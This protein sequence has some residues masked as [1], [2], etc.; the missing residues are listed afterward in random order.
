M[1]TI[2]PFSNQNNQFLDWTTNILACIVSLV[3]SL[4]VAIAA[5]SS[6]IEAIGKLEN[7]FFQH[8]YPKDDINARLDRLEQIV[9]GEAKQGLEA[10]RIANLI[11]AVPASVTKS[12]NSAGLDNSLSKADSKPYES[13]S[14]GSNNSGMQKAIKDTSSTYEPVA[15]SSEYPAVTAIEKRLFGKDYAAEGIIKRLERLET[16]EF[17]K[18]SNIDDLSERVDKLK[19]A[20]GIDIAKQAPP[21][22]DWADDEEGGDDI[23]YHPPASNKLV[24]KSADNEDGKSFSGRD[25]REDM[26]RAFGS[27]RGYTGSSGTYGS[28]GIINS[29]DDGYTPGRG[30][31]PRAIGSGPIAA[32]PD[33]AKNSY[34]TMPQAALGL[35][36]QVSLLEKEIFGKT[37]GNDTI[38]ERLNRLETTVF[39]QQKPAA[40]KAIPERVK[41]LLAAVPLSNNQGNKIA[42]SNNSSDDFFDDM[43]M[44]GGPIKQKMP[45]QAG[46]GKII[47]GLSNFFTG[48]FAGGY[49]YTGNLVTDPQT[50]LLYDPYSGSYVDPMTGV[51][52]Q[53]S[54]S[55][56]GTGGFGT[57]S[58]NSF[59]NGFSPMSPY[60]YG[61]GGSGMRFGFG[62][63]GI[64]L[65]TGIWP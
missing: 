53:R 48:G 1:R 30:S 4:N 51:V 13:N 37:Y 19:R 17:G 34:N 63:G 9:F 6:D 14:L 28:S 62:S 10:D 27:S 21:G 50:G 24:Y 47:N 18:V 33:M 58:F 49:P 64:G 43:D 41:R 59:N 25:L 55:S 56:Y 11:S 5:T 31:Y 39:A 65:G 8:D 29:Q 23:T 52:V 2:F 57:G 45:K 36:Q 12:D 54:M 38:P 60:G 7:K 46:L 61:M 42:A 20:T 22:S 35:G 40:D 16:K 3:L 44:G 26:R 15:N 32:A